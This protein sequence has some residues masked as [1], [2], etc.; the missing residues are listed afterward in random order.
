MSA[1]IDEQM[2]L[3]TRTKA[4]IEAIVKAHADAKAKF[5]ANA[6]AIGEIVKQMQKTEAEATA[7]MKDDQDA[8]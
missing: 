7:E 3:I 6:I 5:D 4:E 8:I 2:D 1:T